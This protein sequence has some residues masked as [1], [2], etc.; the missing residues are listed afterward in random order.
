MGSMT[1]GSQLGGD[2]GDGGDGLKKG[3]R[4]K[5]KPD[6]L[7]FKEKRDFDPKII[8]ARMKELA[9]LNSTATFRF[10]TPVKTNKGKSSSKKTAA[11]EGDDDDVAKDG[12]GK[13][14]GG[15]AAE[16]LG[17]KAVVTVD[18]VEYDELV[19]NYPGGLK[20]Y[21]LDLNAGSEALHDPITFRA[22]VDGVQVEGA[23]QW[24]KEAFTDTLLARAARPFT[25]TPRVCEPAFA[26]LCSIVSSPNV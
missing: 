4:V 1:E 20:D 14:E 21:V 5:F 8:L 9:F 18:G 26:R 12:G 23:L 15:A 25:R 13:E 22:E 17:Q 6:A 19:L 3:T 24:T 10:R 11:A 16:E 2:E 7:I